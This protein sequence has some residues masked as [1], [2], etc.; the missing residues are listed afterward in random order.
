MFI[1][2]DNLKLNKYNKG[3]IVIDRGPISTL[4]YNIVRHELESTFFFF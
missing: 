3:L 4:S 2:N 1:K